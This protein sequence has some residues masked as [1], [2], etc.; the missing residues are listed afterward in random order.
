MRSGARRGTGAA[1][2]AVLLAASCTPS[3]GDAPPGSQTPE[4]L[5]ERQFRVAAESVI[6]VREDALRSGDLEAFMAT[7]DDDELQFVATQRRWFDNLAQLPLGGVSLEVSEATLPGS[8]RDEDSRLRLPVDFTMRLEGF[9][10][11]SVTQRLVYTFTNAPDGLVLAADRDART[12]KRAEW[13][14]DPWDIT[15]VVVRQSDSILAI[16]DEDTAHYADAVMKDLEASRRA[17]MAAIPAWTGRLVAYDI[18]DLTNIAERSPMQVSETGGVAYP[19]LVRP[20]SDRVAAYRFVVNPDVAHNALSREFLLRHE[21]TH[22]ALGPRD[23]HSPRWLVEGAAGHVERSHYTS[24]QQRA[25]AA[26]VLSGLGAQVPAL[27]NGSDF[28][29]N[30]PDVNYTIAAAACS[31]L[32]E[33]RGPDVLWDLM[34]AFTEAARRAGPESGLSAR[35]ADELMVREIGLDNAGLTL[36]AF[37]WA[38]DSG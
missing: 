5:T 3:G 7:V 4:V 28:Y 20:G 18:T 27:A 12:D 8:T 15:H 37:R 22:V 36:A 13:L 35:A 32:V 31:Y 1:L 33:T 16:F 26:Y 38:L 19:V 29:T 23:D 11:R 24:A 25:M 21:L 34:D 9:E 14:P 6:A 2:T 10:D 30:N 17:V